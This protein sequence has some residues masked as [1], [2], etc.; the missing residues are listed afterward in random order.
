M[1][2]YELEIKL[3]VKNALPHIY[4]F[5]HFIKLYKHS[6]FKNGKWERRKTQSRINLVFRS[7]AENLKKYSEKA[8]RK[9]RPEQTANAAIA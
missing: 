7:T 5:G 1:L 4:H 2:R 3:Y 9:R 8:N 6:Y